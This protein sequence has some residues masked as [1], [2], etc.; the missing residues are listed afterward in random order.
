MNEGKIK[1]TPFIRI[2]GILLIIAGIAG[3][4]LTREKK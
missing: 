2:L 1:K 3:L 4:F